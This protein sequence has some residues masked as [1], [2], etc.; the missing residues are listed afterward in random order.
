MKHKTIVN[1]RDITEQEQIRAI[2]RYEKQFEKPSFLL[3]TPRLAQDL[4]KI[5]AQAKQDLKDS[6]Q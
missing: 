4:D 3:K 5:I 6:R 2:N 1:D